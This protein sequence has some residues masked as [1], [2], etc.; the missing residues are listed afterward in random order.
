[1]LTLG[2]GSGSQLSAPKTCMG[3]WVQVVGKLRRMTRLSKILEPPLKE[4]GAS[5]D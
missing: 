5:H 3:A 4:S 1:M 2:D